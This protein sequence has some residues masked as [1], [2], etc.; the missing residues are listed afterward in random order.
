LFTLNFLKN[1]CVLYMN[2]LV[3]QPVC[4]K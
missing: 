2:W 3:C 1:K 4:C